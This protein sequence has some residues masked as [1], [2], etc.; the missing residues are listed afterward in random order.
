MI[1]Y[2]CSTGYLRRKMVTRES[3]L[4]E[5]AKEDELYVDEATGDYYHYNKVLLTPNT[6]AKQRMD[7]L[8]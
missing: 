5:G 7:S 1:I 6:K 2:Y 8:R 3:I 4:S